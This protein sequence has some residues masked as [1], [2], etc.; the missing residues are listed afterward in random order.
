MKLDDQITDLCADIDQWKG[1]FFADDGPAIL[2]A[3]AN[4]LLSRARDLLKEMLAE[5][6]SGRPGG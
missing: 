1:Q 2:V 5:W 3:R 4:D 6:P